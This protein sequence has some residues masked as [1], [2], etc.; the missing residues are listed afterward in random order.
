M[1]VGDGVS[2]R[3][4]ALE[5]ILSKMGSSRRLQRMSYDVCFRKTAFTACKKETVEGKM[6][7]Q[8]G[9]IEVS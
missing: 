3:A 5:S 4:R 6:E 9:Q 8:R 7:G 2:E 1:E